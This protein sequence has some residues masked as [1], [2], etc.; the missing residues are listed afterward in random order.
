MTSRT[1][2]RSLSARAPPRAGVRAPKALKPPGGS[3]SQA[4]VRPAQQPRCSSLAVHG[5]FP[6]PG[7]A[8]AS[9]AAPPTGEGREWQSSAARGDQLHPPLLDY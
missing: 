4:A 8:P 6:A 9:W 7:A 5:S 2:R 3:S 1:D